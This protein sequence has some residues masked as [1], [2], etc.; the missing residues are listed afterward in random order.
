MDIMLQEQNIQDIKQPIL[1]LI[2]PVYY[3]QDN[4]IKLLDDIQE[5]IKIPIKLYIIYDTEIDPTVEVV[6]KIKDQYPFPVDLIL[7]RIGPGALNAI[8]TGLHIFKED[9]CVIIMADSSDDLNTINGMYGLFCQGF[10]IV[11]ASR[12]MRN[13]R[14]IGGNYLKK[15][16]SKIAGK[17]LYYITK[18]PTHDVTNSFKLYSKEA[19]SQINIKSSG[20]FEIGMEIVV[21]SFLKGLAIA[22]V[23]TI[24]HDRYVGNSKFKLFK[25]LPHYLKW[26]LLILLKNPFINHKKIKYNKIRKIGA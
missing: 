19:I 12:Y 9:A 13:G 26:Y 11:C 23:P 24:W 2:V 18:L 5:K 1:A 14:Q 20:G 6:K 25:W 16:L 4:I 10:H 17:S 22:E 15:V 7:N 21:K 3:E 8:K